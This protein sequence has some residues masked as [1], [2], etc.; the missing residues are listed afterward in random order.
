MKILYT[1]KSNMIM[2]FICI[3]IINLFI[4]CADSPTTNTA[5]ANASTTA[6][7]KQ[8]IDNSSAST[9]TEVRPARKGGPA[10]IVVNVKNMVN[11]KASLIGYYAESHY[12]ADTAAVNNGKFVFKNS[13]GYDQGLYFIS[14]GQD[15]FAQVLLADDQKFTISLDAMDPINTIVVKGSEENELFYDN[16]KYEQDFNQRFGIVNNQLK[17]QTDG[18]LEYKR[19]STEKETLENERINTLE[20]LFKKHPNK[21]F[22][23]FKMAGQNPRIR[24]NATDAEQVYHFRNEFWDNVDFSDER[25][26]RTPVINNKLKRYMKELTPQNSDSIV[27]YAK[28][29]IDKTLQ[30][31]EYYKYFSNWVVLEYEPGKS[32]IMDSEAIFVNLTREYFTR[33]R[34]FWADSMEVYAIINRGREMGNSL[35]GQQGP[36][37]TVP[38][39]DG[40]PKTLYDSKADYI[41]VYLYA[42][43]CEHCQEETPK[44]VQWYNENKHRSYDVYAIAIDTEVQEWKDYVAKNNMTFTNVHDPSNRSIYAT[45]YV[46]VT[47]ELYLLNKER[48]IIGKNLK[49]FQLQQMIDKDKN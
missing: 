26:L 3:A 36:N 31:P 37:I 8:A 1:M 44:L 11:P 14:I 7:T 47:P 9:V 35:V 18:T 24:K 19:L 6:Q 39:I 12:T 42:P 48:K 17:Q 33:E 41:V 21:L 16:L 10:E 23:K 28:Q 49:T 20:S 27:F 4:G 15:K 43:S 30:Y 22:T 40:N 2:T 29:L 25:L 38:G 32:T 45:Y 34:A 5:T 46:D 13:D